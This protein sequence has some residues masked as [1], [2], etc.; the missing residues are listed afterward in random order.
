MYGYFIATSLL[1]KRKNRHRSLDSVRTLSGDCSEPLGAGKCDPHVSRDRL[2]QCLNKLV[3]LDRDLIGIGLSIGKLLQNWLGW[4]QLER[5]FCL[6][7]VGPALILPYRK[8]V[9]AGYRRSCDTYEKS[10]S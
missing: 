9:H 6:L 10:H 8:S 3:S 7:F 4:I 2:N 1:H 5:M